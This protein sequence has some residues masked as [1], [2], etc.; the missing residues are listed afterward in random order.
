MKCKFRENICFFVYIQGYE[1]N[2]SENEN[3]IICE[4]NAE[5]RIIESALRS[6]RSF[7][8]ELNYLISKKVVTQA[9][10]RALNMADAYQRGIDIKRSFMALEP[11][12]LND[13]NFKNDLSHDVGAKNVGEI[14]KRIE[15]LKFRNP[16]QIVASFQ[17]QLGRLEQR[18]LVEGLDICEVLG[19]KIDQQELIKCVNFDFGNFGFCESII[20][21]VMSVSAYAVNPGTDLTT[22]R[23]TMAAIAPRTDVGEQDL[24]DD[25]EF[26]I[27]SVE[28]IPPTPVGA[29]IKIENNIEN[30][31]GKSCLEYNI[32]KNLK[33]VIELKLVLFNYYFEKRKVYEDRRWGIADF[34]QQA[35]SGNEPATSP[36]GLSC[37]K[38]NFGTFP[39]CTPCKDKS[40]EHKK[41]RNCWICKKT[42]HFLILCRLLLCQYARIDTR[43][44][45]RTIPLSSKIEKLHVPGRR[46]GFGNSGFSGYNGYNGY[47]NNFSGYNNYNNRR[48]DY[49]GGAGGNWNHHS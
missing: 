29:R 28:E 2:D 22:C 34:Y 8:D 4:W 15:N 23:P 11:Y 6:G 26:K 9:V 25:N 37:F 7:E 1:S 39:F 24:G 13:F 46:G 17:A 10:G 5:R 45:W 47:N 48:N 40:E 14:N 16:A 19:R 44:N 20:N 38:C 31:V 42:D 43:A 49:R 32:S 18:Y 21:N 3:G 41:F 35:I 33:C 27:G 12:S 36:D 30:R